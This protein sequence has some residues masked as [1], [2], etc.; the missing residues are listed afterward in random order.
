MAQRN[1]IW[2][3]TADI[4]FVGILEYWVKKNK[5]NIYSIEL[6]KLVSERT[7]Q[8]AENPLLYIV[9]DFKNTRVASLGNFSIYYKYN[10]AEI[11]IT[12]FWDNRQ[13]PKKLV[14]LLESKK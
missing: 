5:S 4:Q 3:R 7:K 13:N 12:A 10:D 2:T 9:T 8:I 11:I 14:K 1:V 6:L